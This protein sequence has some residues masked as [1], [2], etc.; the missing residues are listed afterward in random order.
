[1]DTLSGFELLASQATMRPAWLP[2]VSFILSAESGVRNDAT[3]HHCHQ[4]ANHN[5]P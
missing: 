4:H 5:D 1:L 2:M 3:N